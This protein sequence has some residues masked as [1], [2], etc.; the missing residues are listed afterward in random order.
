MQINEK[1]SAKRVRRD[2]RGRSGRRPVLPPPNSEGMRLLQLVDG[3]LAELAAPLGCSRVAVLDWRAGNKTPSPEARMAMQQAFSIPFDAW[4]VLPGSPLS[5]PT[6]ALAEAGPLPS[7]EDCLRELLAMLRRLHRGSNGPMA[8]RCASTEV[9][10]LA[11][12]HAIETDR[13]MQE[14]RMVYEHPAW[15]AL[16]RRVL[17]AL[18]PFPDAAH[19]VAAAL[20][21][22]PT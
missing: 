3:S 14:A 8:S 18:E 2:V 1:N 21:T 20:S 15:I 6:A 12:L 16:K 22:N 5:S 17:V 7:T 13:E 19:A 11:L 4:D 9:R 10:V